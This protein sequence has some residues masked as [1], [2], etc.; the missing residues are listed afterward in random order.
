[1]ADTIEINAYAKI[2]LTLDVMKRLESGYHEIESVKQQITLHDDLMLGT[3]N[4]KTIIVNCKEVPKEKNLAYKAA[5]LLQKK[6]RPE[7]G[8]EIT[9]RKN[10]PIGSGLAGGSADAAATLKGLNKL[11]NLGLKRK[12]LIEIGKEIGMDVP[13]CI[14]GKTAFATGTGAILRRL[15]PIMEFD[16][17]L[18]NPGFR[19]STKQ[20]Y[21]KIDME[22]AG[23]RQST[24]EMVKAIESQN[25]EGVISSLHNDFEANAIK[26][27]PVISEIKKELIKN[28]ALNSLMSGSGPTVFGI[29]DDKEK[30]K[31]AYQSLKDKYAYVCLAKAR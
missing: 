13:F 4:E 28:G 14:F 22:K 24:Q 3:L 16:I 25:K 1:M 6:F 20:A 2:N 29:F 10:I 18:I 7:K 5:L 19:I 26:E 11:W 21:E 30:A 12:E 27:H 15:R 17:I 23:K 8:I 31:K 9:I